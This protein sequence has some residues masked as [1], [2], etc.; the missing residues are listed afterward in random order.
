M[1]FNNKSHNP[2]SYNETSYMYINNISECDSS[3]YYVNVITFHKKVKPK[4]VNVTTR[5]QAKVKLQGVSSKPS[6][7]QM[8][9]VYVPKSTPEMSK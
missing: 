7:S 3:Q 9:V 6:T 4:N 5:N 2:A 8:K 1:P